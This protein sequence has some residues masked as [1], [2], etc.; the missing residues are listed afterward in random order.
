MDPLVELTQTW[1]QG[2]AGR[3]LAN[4]LGAW[5]LE[6]PVLRSFDAEPPALFRFLRSR[7][8]GERDAVFCALL[9]QATTDQLAGMVVLEALLPG[10]KALSG[11][12]LVEAGQAEELLASLLA[13]AWEGIVGYPVERRPARVAAN[14]LLD[15]R[16]AT[17][18]ELRHRR[19]NATAGQ[20]SGR[21]QPPPRQA[22]GELA[23]MRA[24]AAGAIKRAEAELILETR[25]G[26]RSL[27]ELAA[28]QGVGYRA[29]L[30]RRIRAEKRL[31]LFLGRPVVTFRGSNRHMCT[32]RPVAH[33][34]A[35]SASGGA[36]TRPHPR[37]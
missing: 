11:S 6:E 1:R 8:S 14:L 22:D 4:R 31:L 27:H 5:A 37:R 15:V 7:P 34:A 36:G 21:E 29:L 23:V 35:D 24:L 16:K 17:V 33:E 9:R 26:G 2:Q 12:I 19:R 25:F 20:L 10:L 18:N 3:R 13:H 28:E 30:A 32:A